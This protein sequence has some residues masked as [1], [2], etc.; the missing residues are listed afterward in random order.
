MEKDVEE[1]L[2]KGLDGLLQKAGVDTSVCA[3]ILFGSVAKGLS[4]SVSDVDVC[5]VLN[6]R[7]DL[8]SMSLKKLEYL[9]LAEYDVSIFQQL[10]LYVRRRVIKEGNILLCRSEDRLYEIVL[11]TIKEFGDFEP[12]YYEYLDGVLHAR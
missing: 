6:D 3:V 12:I 4:N 2:G 8:L 5:I 7:L 9:S 10:P 11:K 1:I